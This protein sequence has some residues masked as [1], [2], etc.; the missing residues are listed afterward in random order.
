[1]TTSET[2]TIVLPDCIVSQL[3]TEAAAAGD[4][5]QVADCDVLLVGDL[6]PGD[7]EYD[8]AMRRT[9]RTL[10]RAAAAAR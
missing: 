4:E 5:K 8:A 10:E 9:V 7:D 2:E 6:G 3:R 1:M